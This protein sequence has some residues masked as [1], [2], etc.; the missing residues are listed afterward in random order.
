MRLIS[1]VNGRSEELELL[2]DLA[3]KL[4]NAE[5]LDT[6]LRAIYRFSADEFRREIAEIAARYN[7]DYD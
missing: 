4:S 6:E 7:N 2:F 1:W 5:F 3:T